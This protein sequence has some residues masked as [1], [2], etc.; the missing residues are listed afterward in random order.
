ML[1]LELPAKRQLSLQCL[2]PSVLQIKRASRHV[3]H[4]DLV[5]Q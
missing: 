3:S 2:I 1:S 5:Q 4:L